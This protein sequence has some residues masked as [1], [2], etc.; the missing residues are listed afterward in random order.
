PPT[1]PVRCTGFAEPAGFSEEASCLR[2]KRRASMRGALRVWSAGSAATEGPRRSRSRSRSRSTATATAEAVL[3][4][5]RQS[6]LTADHRQFDVARRVGGV[7]HGVVGHHRLAFGFV[8]AA[9][10]EVAREL[11]EV[12]A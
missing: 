6:I 8:G 4:L 7:V 10:I 11:G 12:R 9:G 2:G 5:V 1:R 3:L